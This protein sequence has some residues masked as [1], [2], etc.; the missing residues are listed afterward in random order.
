MKI[1]IAGATGFIGREV[2]TQCRAKSSITSIIVLTR[3]PLSEDLSDDPK[4]VPVL[5]EN[6][7]DYSKDAKEK[8]QGASAA[9]W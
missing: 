6:F 2:L 9:I 3:R 5:V 8:M 1:I 4:V 7:L